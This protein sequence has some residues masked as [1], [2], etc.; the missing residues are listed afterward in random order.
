[1][2][3]GL[4]YFMEQVAKELDTSICESCLKIVPSIETERNA[5]ICGYC[6]INGEI[7]KEN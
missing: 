7:K 4:K 3:K 2:D 1:M 6:C 5:G